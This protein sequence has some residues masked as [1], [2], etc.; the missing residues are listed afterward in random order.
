MSYRGTARGVLA[1]L[2]IIVGGAI[3]VVAVLAWLAMYYSG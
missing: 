1:T 3:G 2:L